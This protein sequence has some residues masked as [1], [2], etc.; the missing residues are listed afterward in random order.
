M[1]RERSV[2]EGAA[3]FARE[4]GIHRLALEMHPN[5]MVYNRHT[6]SCATRW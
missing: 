5:F 1:E 3:K 2:L 4:H 6:I